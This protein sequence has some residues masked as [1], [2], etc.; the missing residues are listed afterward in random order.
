MTPPPKEGLIDQFRVLD[1]T[2]AKAQLAGKILGDMGADVIKVEPPGGDPART[3]PPFYRDEPNPEQSLYWWAYNTSKRGVTL[4]LTTADGRDLF[5]RLVAGADLVLESY[6]PG[7][8]AGV[9]LGYGDLVSA[10]SD[11]VLV[12]MTPF[13]QTGPY[14]GHRASD[15]VSVAM[16]GNMFL[17]GDADRPPV[18]CQ[19]PTTHFHACCET[20]GAALMGLW[21]REVYGEGQHV[22][23]SIHE[24][25]QLVGFSAPGMYSINGQRGHRAGALYQVRTPH[26]MTLQREIWPCKDGFVSFGLRGGP[27]RIPGFQRLAQWM[28]EEGMGDDFIN[29][30]DWPTYNN[31]TFSQDEVDSLVNAIQRFFMTKTAI[32]LY[33][34]AIEK[35]LM[36]APV[37]NPRQQLADKHLKDRG[38]FVPVEHEEQGESFLYPGF[39]AK[40]DHA[41]VGIRRRAPRIGEHNVDIFE[42]ELGLERHELV[43]LKEAGI[44]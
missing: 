12:S 21:H 9:G 32:E 42:G 39:F 44:I 14:S 17:T 37:Y 20:A 30:I 5:K 41:F 31:N 19:M 40:S 33:E 29:S 11:V 3:I 36:I 28:N 7:Y 27:A 6:D 1:L 8:L 23:V 25:M 15:F 4:D 38:F 16:S 13:G 24:V 18:A 34:A 10:K 26:G 43:G 22:D 2:D 35:V